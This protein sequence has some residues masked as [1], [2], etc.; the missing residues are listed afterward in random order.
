[1]AQNSTQD[2][3]GRKVTPIKL[4][5]RLCKQ[6]VEC[7]DNLLAVQ[8]VNEKHPE[9]FPVAI[10]ALLNYI[11]TYL[12]FAPSDLPRWERNRA[13]FHEEFVS[14]MFSLINDLPNERVTKTR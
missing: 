12:F 10:S 14:D 1:M 11:L 5:C 7:T 9:A 4:F 6:E 8:H 3:R 13:K 2:T